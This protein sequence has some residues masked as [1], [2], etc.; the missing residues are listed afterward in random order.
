MDNFLQNQLY[1]WT[2]DKIK[3]NPKYYGSDIGNPAIILT[4][5]EEMKHLSINTVRH[6]VAV[7]RIRNKLLEKF[8]QYDCRVKYK[9]KSKKGVKKAL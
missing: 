3:A 9:P 7:S 2:Y 5:L 8:P 6:S 1:R 4:Y